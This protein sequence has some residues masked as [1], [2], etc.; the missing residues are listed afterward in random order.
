[1][2]EEWLLVHQAPWYVWIPLSLYGV[3]VELFMAIIGLGGFG[4]GIASL[5]GIVSMP[6]I[7]TNPA[8]QSYGIFFVEMLFAA[9][10]GWN[11]LRG[12]WA[13]ILAVF[14]PPLTFEGTLDQLTA[15]V[16]QGKNA[17]YRVWVLKFA[18]KTW[19]IAKLDVERTPFSSHVTV[20]KEIRIQYRRGTEQITQLWVKSTTGRGRR[21]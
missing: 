18:E 1:M 6:I 15:E 5:L 13:E 19:E 8:W 14:T 12:M 17:G 20:G 4:Y 3:I 10:L 9:W 2:A 11:G 21:S 16:R 7:K